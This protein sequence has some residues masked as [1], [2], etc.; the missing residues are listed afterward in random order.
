MLLRLIDFEAWYNE[1]KLR[2]IDASAAGYDAG[3][4]V[5][6]TKSQAYQSGQFGRKEADKEEGEGRDAVWSVP[7]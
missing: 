5:D 6:P 2:E 7:P 3:G 1:W 4:P